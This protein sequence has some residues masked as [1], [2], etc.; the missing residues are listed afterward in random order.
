MKKV[1]S[2]QGSQLVDLYPTQ[3]TCPA[4]EEPL[5]ERYRQSRYIVTLSGM[6]KLNKHVL[7]CQTAECVQRGHKWRPEA[8][9]ALALQWLHLWAGCSSSHRRVTTSLAAD[10]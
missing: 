5:Q 3:R 8:E 7:E 10:H 2:H 9:G 4:C 1:P 6:L